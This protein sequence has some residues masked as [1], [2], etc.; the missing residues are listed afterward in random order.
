MVAITKFSVRTYSATQDGIRVTLQ[1]E[2]E[3]VITIEVLE[4]V[5]ETVTLPLDQYQQ[6]T[7][8]FQQCLAAA[9]NDEP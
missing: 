1:I 4:G 9:E 5:T 8:L 6:M 3:P 7:A 2:P